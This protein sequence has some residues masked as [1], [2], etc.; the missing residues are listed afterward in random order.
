MTDDKV[1]R[2]AQYRKGLGI[3]FFNATNSAIALVASVIGKQQEPTSDLELIARVGKI[4][5][6]FIEQ[7]KEYYAANIAN[8]GANYNSADTIEKMKATKT[9][10]ELHAV[11]SSISE[12]ERRDGDIIKVKDELKKKYVIS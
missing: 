8:I 1:L 6:I 7:H 5:D 9:L 4:R 3:G 2:D 10:M 11:W 12:D